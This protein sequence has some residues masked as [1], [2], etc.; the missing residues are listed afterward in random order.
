M[1]PAGVCIVIIRRDLIGKFKNK[2]PLLCDWETF[3]KAANTFHNTPCCWSIYMAGLNI[4]Y[5][6]SKGGIPAMEELAKKRSGL[7]YDY[8]DNSDGYYSNGI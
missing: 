6:L 8:F 2:M 1:G 7:L 5:M 3:N 4:E